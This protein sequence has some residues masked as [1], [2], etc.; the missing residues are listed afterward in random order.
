MNRNRG[1]P[2]LWF[3]ALVSVVG[4]IGMRL[5]YGAFTKG[6][7][8]MGLIGA[9]LLTAAVIVVGTPLAYAQYVRREAKNKRRK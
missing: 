6:W 2:P 7:V 1:I 9:V 8:V 3:A 5:L 4:I